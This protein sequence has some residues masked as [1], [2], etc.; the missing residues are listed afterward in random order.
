[1]KR[2]L[3]YVGP[4]VSIAIFTAAVAAILSMTQDI[5]VAEVRAAFAGTERGRLAAAVGCIAGVYAVLS[6]YDI[7]A[8]RYIAVPLRLR[9]IMFASFIGNTLGMI[10]GLSLLTGGSLRYRLY[11]R[12]G[13]TLT[14]VA[15][16]TAFGISTLT[17]LLLLASGSALLIDTGTFRFFPSLPPPILRL[18]GVLLLVPVAGYLVAAAFFPRKRLVLFRRSFPVPTLPVALGQLGLAA[19]EVLLTGSALFFLLPSLPGLPVVSFLGLYVLSQLVGFASQTPG[20]LGSFDATMLFLLLP[21]APKETI[22]ASLLLFRIL[23]SLLP[24]VTALLA[25]SL[26]EHRHFRK[27]MRAQPSA[28]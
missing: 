20:G 15:A 24:L 1:M 6:S 27:N 13:L 17:L 14:H 2:L 25:L 12:W 7:L 19:A 9:R 16:I 3:P 4:L 11:T 10:L 5:T 23:F 8:F 18:L 26:Y 28:A 21:F 22:V